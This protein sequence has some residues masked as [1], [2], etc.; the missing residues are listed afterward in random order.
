MSLTNE[1]DIGINISS[2]PWSD[3]HKIE[4]FKCYIITKYGDVSCYGNEGEGCFMTGEMGEYHVFERIFCSGNTRPCFSYPTEHLCL[5][6]PSSAIDSSSIRMCSEGF[7]I[8][9]ERCKIVKSIFKQYPPQLHIDCKD[10]EEAT[11]R[12]LDTL[13]DRGYATPLNKPE[14]LLP[15]QI[16]SEKKLEIFNSMS[17]ERLIKEINSENNE[18]KPEYK[19]FILSETLNLMMSLKRPFNNIDDLIAS[20]NPDQVYPNTSKQFINAIINTKHCPIAVILNMCRNDNYFDMQVYEDIIDNVVQEYGIDDRMYQ[21]VENTLNMSCPP[22][23]GIFHTDLN[24]YNTIYTKL[25]NFEASTYITDYTPTSGEDVWITIYSFIKLISCIKLNNRFIYPCFRNAL[26]AVVINTN[27]NNEN[28]ISSP[29]YVYDKS[30]QFIA[31]TKYSYDIRHIYASTV[32]L[33]RILIKRCTTTEWIKGIT[34]PLKYTYV[35]KPCIPKKKCVLLRYVNMIMKAHNVSETVA[36]GFFRKLN[37]TI[38]GKSKTSFHMILCNQRVSASFD[39][40]VRFVVLFNLLLFKFPSIID[41]EYRP[42]DKR[43]GSL[44]GHVTRTLVVFR[45]RLKEWIEYYENL[46]SV[47]K[48]ENIDLSVCNRYTDEVSF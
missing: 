29:S 25:T 36:T 4:H 45:E 18:K 11:I 17:R 48:N 22:G 35:L 34:I 1:P 30:I 41:G 32:R 46:Q 2:C 47:L 3:K 21:D 39:D 27:H 13:K 8:L 15:P 37:Y 33:F 42:L 43:A 10:A 28:D 20:C 19:T 12:L 38:F 23:Y 7:L 16:F 24:H 40:S 26:E 9:I 5:G 44:M 31:P 6:P 14:P